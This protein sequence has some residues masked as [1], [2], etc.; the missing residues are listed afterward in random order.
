MFAKYRHIDGAMFYGNEID[1]GNGIRQKIEEK[2]VKREDLF[3]VSKVR[4]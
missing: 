1:V 3:L 4:I 2:V